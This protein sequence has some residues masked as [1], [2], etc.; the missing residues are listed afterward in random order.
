MH[1]YVMCK[2]QQATKKRTNVRTNKQENRDTTHDRE[3]VINVGTNCRVY[4]KPGLKYS[5]TSPH[6]L[7]YSQSYI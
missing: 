4:S 2:K 5:T 1:T 7:H 3:S 6:P